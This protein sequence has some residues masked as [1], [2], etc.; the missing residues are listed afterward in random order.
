MSPG[1]S[2]TYLLAT[3]DGRVLVNTG[4][5][6]EGPMH[7]RAYEGTGNGPLRTI[8]LTQG[9]YDHV[10][11]VDVLREEAT[12]VVAQANF[13]FWRADNERLE[14]FRV[15]NAAFAWMDAI[16]AATTHAR[17]LGVG[18]TAQARP[19]PTTTFD[20][21]LDL[22]VGGRRLS[23]LSVPGGETTDALAI[24]LAESHTA[25]TGNMVGPLF[26]HVPNLVTMRGDRYRDALDYVAS[27]D[28][29]LALRPHRLI[30]GHF[31]PIDGE[32]RIAEEL[33]A[34]R[35]AMLWVHDRTVEGMNAGTDVHTLMRE[36]VLP[37]HFDLGE[38]YGKTSWNVRAIWENYAG[39]FHHRS[40]TELY[41]VPPTA[42]ASDVVAAA[43]AAVLLD[44][45]RRHLDAHRPVHALHLV[46]L[47][48]AAEPESAEARSTAAAATRALLEQS[49][50]FWETAWLRRQLDLLEGAQ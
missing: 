19:E 38:G 6:F 27:V 15:R 47:V 33:T 49:V 14:S 5:G 7:L 1:L 26:G 21:N 28:R 10:G 13:P 41:G 39:W 43:G 20:D 24:W 11:G 9:H 34:L 30:T 42:V 44:A 4:M 23:L 17:S 25:F 22:E 16:A 18:A 32:D 46:D 12:D 35:D 50:N 36:I 2:N 37:E 48:L 8:V 40:T 45:A 3:D 29:V 31:D